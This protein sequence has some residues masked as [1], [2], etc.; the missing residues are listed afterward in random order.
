MCGVQISGLH[1]S[2]YSSES[3]VHHA[4]E[5]RLRQEEM[6]LRGFLVFNENRNCFLLGLKQ[7]GSMH[8]K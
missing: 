5:G 2:F 1:S 8:T 6:P 7:H 4:E 3:L